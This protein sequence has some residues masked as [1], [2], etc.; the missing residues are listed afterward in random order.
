MV[1]PEQRLGQPPCVEL[2]E[3]YLLRQCVAGDEPS[4]F[5]LM[6]ACGWGFNEELL[7]YCRSRLL[8]AGW[9]VVTSPPSVAVVASAMSLHNYT[10]R[11]TYS[12]TLGWVGCLPGHRGNGLGAAVASAAT[13]RLLHGGYWD[14]ELYTEHFRQPA[15]ETY[16][17]LGYVPYIYSDAV[18]E[19][20]RAVC[21][22]LGREFTPQAWPHGDNAYPSS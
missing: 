5:D 9:F 1:W 8:P 13:A 20:W 12:G 15:I 16:F 17:R 19:T 6:S 22:Q 18:A 7:R 10:G 4:F 2:H 14:V 11:S 21:R 3:R